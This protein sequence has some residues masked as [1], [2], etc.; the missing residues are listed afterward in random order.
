VTDSNGGRGDLSVRASNEQYFRQKVVLREGLVHRRNDACRNCLFTGLWRQPYELAESDGVVAVLANCPANSV[1]WTS[2]TM[3][4]N[5]TKRTSLIFHLDE[6]AL[7]LK[8]L[9]N[10]I[11]SGHLTPDDAVELLTAFAHVQEH[12]CL[13]WHMGVAVN[14]V[15]ISDHEAAASIPNWNQTFHISNPSY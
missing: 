14:P 15:P 9:A 5:D 4:D 13:A 7:H 6:A 3:S 11:A 8:E 1:A 10:D 2:E 12:L